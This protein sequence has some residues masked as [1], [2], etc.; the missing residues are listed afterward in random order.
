MHG[1]V[2]PSWLEVSS[3]LVRV[4]GWRYHLYGWQKNA[5]AVCGRRITVH[6]GA[7]TESI[8][9]SAHN[10]CL[11]TGNQVEKHAGDR[12]LYF[13]SM[14]EFNTTLAR[15]LKEWSTLGSLYLPIDSPWFERFDEVDKLDDYV[16]LVNMGLFS[17]MY[18][19]TFRAIDP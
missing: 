7:V 15:D 5:C 18:Y 17:D 12:T 16:I 2:S 19:S 8:Y 14:Y 9:G 13:K 10:T 4:K 11:A 1:G 6:G 3:S